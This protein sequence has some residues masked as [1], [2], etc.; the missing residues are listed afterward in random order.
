MVGVACGK[1]ISFGAQAIAAR[2]LANREP[3]GGELL[4]P[5]GSSARGGLMWLAI[6]RLLGPL[7]AMIPSSIGSWTGLIGRD[8]RPSMALY[9]AERQRELCDEEDR[10]A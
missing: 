8:A 5:T 6:R 1:I 4:C 2:V 3:R 10:R 9:E 7:V